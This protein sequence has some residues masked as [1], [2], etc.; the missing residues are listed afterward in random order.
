MASIL[1]TDSDG[2]WKLHNGLPFPA[3]R[4]GNWTPDSVPVGD[5]AA[6]LSDG[7][8]TMFRLRTDYGASFEL[9]HIPSLRANNG[10][11]RSEEFDH[12]SWT[13]TRLSVAVNDVAP[14]GSA[15][16]D[17]LTEDASVTTSH[18]ISQ[19]P[20]AM[21]ASTTYCWSVF[22]KARTRSWLVLEVED[23]GGTARSAYFNAATGA[24]GT[25]GNSPLGAKTYSWGNGW[26]R[27]ELLMSS[28]TGGG[29]GACRIYLAAADGGANYTGDGTSGLL[30]WGAMF[31]PAIYARPYAYT[32]GVAKSSCSQSDTADRLKQHLL[33]GGSCTVYTND[34][35]ATVVGS[36]S[37]TIYTCGLKPGTVP[38]LVLSDR[39]A[40]EYTL[41]VQ[42][43]NLAASPV[44]MSAFYADQ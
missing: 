21:V 29:A 17:L 4:F 11:L 10:I 44:R 16:A 12:A 7:T 15:S 35:N 22:A 28:A 33:N 20:S 23:K 19:V 41:S 13:K 39:R 36:P 5:A 37:A 30:V 14:D 38:Q 31:D 25:L 24:V 32:V 1:F 27:C 3:D 43:I 9:A 8:I 2:T 26:F 40:L 18:L 34:S 42:L 6:R